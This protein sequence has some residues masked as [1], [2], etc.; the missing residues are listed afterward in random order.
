MTDRDS[1]ASHPFGPQSGEDLARLVKDNPLAWIVSGAGASFRASLMPVRPWKF[2]EGRLTQLAGHL[3]RRNDQTDLLRDSPRAHLLFLGP[4]GY[5]SPTWVTDRTWTP[6][7][8]F[9]S[10]RIDVEIEFLDDEAS[11]RAVLE[12]LVEAMEAGRTDAWRIEEMGSRYAELARRIVAFRAHV[13]DV[14]E[15]Y[16]LGQ[17]EGAGLFADIIR[18]LEEA[19]EDELK[20]WMVRFNEG[21]LG[22]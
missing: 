20:E 4:H 18:G 3:P 13:T 6:T 15:R 7:W 5:I 19:G 21:K 14:H 22:E 9:A 10:A 8:N 2:E 17:D 12:D 11:L 1:Q 16:K